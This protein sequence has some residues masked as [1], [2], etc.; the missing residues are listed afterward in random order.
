VRPGAGVLRNE[1]SIRPSEDY[2]HGLNE[3]IPVNSF[4]DGL[5]FWYLL[6]QDLAGPG[7]S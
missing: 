6:L 3:R 1:T 4:Y 7:P 2:S 5:K